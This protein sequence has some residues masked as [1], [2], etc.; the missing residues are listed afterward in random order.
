MSVSVVLKKM[1]R[2]EF[3]A[4][5]KDFYLKYW[6]AARIKAELGKVHGESVPSLKS[7]N[8]WI[9]GFKRG[10]TATKDETRSG[11]PI[12]VTASDIVEE[13]HHMVIED[14]QM[15]VHEISKIV[16]I[17]TE[18]VYKILHEK[19]EDR[20]VCARWVPRLLTPDQKSDREDVSAQCLAK[21]NRNPQ[22]FFR[23]FVTVNETWINHYIPESEEQTKQWVLPGES[24][25]REFYA[26]NFQIRILNRGQVEKLTSLTKR[27]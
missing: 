19:L 15:K 3:H 12:K 18:Q 6:M 9:N 17:S 20:K 14:C 8:F 27:I 4:V 22:E 2:E 13:I 5:I 11:R 16:D 24:T 23:R 26:K 21:F 1:E 10:Q 7:V 25:R